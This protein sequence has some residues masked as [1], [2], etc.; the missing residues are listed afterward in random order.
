MENHIKAVAN[1][2]W[3]EIKK[4]IPFFG[5]C[6]FAVGCLNIV[7]FHLKEFSAVPTEE[8][9]ADALFS[10]FLS[11]HVFGLF[12]L[13]LLC[14]G[15]L[16]ACLHA[17]K[18]N[19]LWLEKSV[20]HLETRFT[21]LTSSIISFTVGLL[22]FVG[23]HA[24]GTDTQAIAFILALILFDCIIVVGFITAALFARHPPPFDKWYVGLGMLIISVAT[25]TWLIF[26]GT[27]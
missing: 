12:Y 27:K 2:L 23:A 26:Y 6:G 1:A 24:V 9:W 16:V 22:L 8:P 17:L 14:F 10:D 15:S 21:Q 4:D 20:D 3:Q 11:F 5:I 25:I 13:A 18:I 19:W 7:Q